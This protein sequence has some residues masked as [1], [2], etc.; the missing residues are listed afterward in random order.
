MKESVFRHAWRATMV[1]VLCTCIAGCVNANDPNAVSKGT[2]AS[3]NQY[4]GTQDF[5]GPVS[6]LNG[7]ILQGTFLVR[8]S[9]KGSAPITE[10]FHQIYVTVSAD[11]WLFLDSAWANGQALRFV[12]IDRSVSTCG[13]YGCIINETVGV[14]ITYDELVKMA[15][16]GFSFQLR[17]Q[18]GNRVV[19]IP[20]SYF[21]GYLRQVRAAVPA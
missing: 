8:G 14:N 6:P 12:P 21:Q 2:S 19:T 16:T 13:S 3:F 4:T 11:G 18:R 5:A 10:T 7:N 15:L 17:G 1:A 20:A 9:R